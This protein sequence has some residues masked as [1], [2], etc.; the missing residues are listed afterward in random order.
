MVA[1]VVT[2]CYDAPM[3]TEIAFWVPDGKGYKVPVRCDEYQ[4]ALEDEINST[5]DS[6]G[7]IESIRQKLTESKQR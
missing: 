1:G 5:A 7:Q 2:V 3:C 6:A 4:Q